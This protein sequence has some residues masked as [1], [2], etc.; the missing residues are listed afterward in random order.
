MGENFMSVFVFTPLL[1]PGKIRGF[2]G[3]WEQPNLT[4]KRYVQKCLNKKLK[5]TD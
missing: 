4:Q 3:I 2:F 5:E 1:D